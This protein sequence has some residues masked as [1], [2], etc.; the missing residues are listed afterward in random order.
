[1]CL[2]I[3]VFNVSRLFHSVLSPF[4]VMGV[5]FLSFIYL[6]IIF[7][8]NDDDENNKNDCR[9]VFIIFLYFH[10]YVAGFSFSFNFF[11]YQSN[12]Q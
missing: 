5:A 11:V 9:Y 7:L 10:Q 8:L 3:L 2:C 1:M 4:M 12:N 6:F